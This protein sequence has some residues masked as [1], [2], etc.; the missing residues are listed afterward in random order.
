LRALG[1]TVLVFAL[2]TATTAQAAEIEVSFVVNSG[3][4]RIG[5]S[6]FPLTTDGSAGLTG[7]IDDTTGEFTGE[8]VFPPSQTTLPVTA[9]IPGTLTINLSIE[10]E[11]G[12]GTFD[13]DT[14]EITSTATLD[15]I[16]EFVQLVPTAPPSTPIP[17]GVTCTL[18]DIV[19]DLSTS[20]DGTPYAPLPADPANEEGSFELT[21]SGFTVPLPDCVGA[22]AALVTAV[23]DGLV[24]QLGLPQ[25]N[26][27]VVIG[28]VTGEIQP[29]A[30]LPTTTVTAPPPAPV[31]PVAASAPTFTG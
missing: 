13:P 21:A 3:F 9:P 28:Y 25:T 4:F 24:A 16:L 14:G 5:T 7:T 2:F 27:E 6:E 17:L 31:A 12:G 18:A 26:T 11:S 22:N 8:S 1:A 20:P 19:L 15:I 10:S 23:R 29:P 30:P